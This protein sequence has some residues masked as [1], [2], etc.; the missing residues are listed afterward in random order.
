M[1]W[2]CKHIRAN[3]KLIGKG[4]SWEICGMCGAYRQ[5]MPTPLT[6]K[7]ILPK[8]WAYHGERRTWPKGSK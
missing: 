7:W 1:N 4:C 8:L 6:S 3:V 5:L 2:P